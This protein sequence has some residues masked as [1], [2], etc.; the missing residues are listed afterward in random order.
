MTKSPAQKAWA[1]ATRVVLPTFEGGGT[2][3]NVSGVVLAKY[4]P[5]KANAMK[6]IEW[7]VGDTAQHMYADSVFEYPLRN[8]VAV[9]PIIAGYGTLKPDALPLSKIAEFKKAAAT[10]VDKV[11]F[12][13]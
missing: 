4:A 12:D 3:V 6:L 10:L 9:N 7:L 2:H 8:G 13:N 1:D 5:N 11:G